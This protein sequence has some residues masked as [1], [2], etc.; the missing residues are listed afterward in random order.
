MIMRSLPVDENLLH[1]VCLYVC[2]SIGHSALSGCREAAAV[3]RDLRRNDVI[4]MKAGARCLRS[5]AIKLMTDDVKQPA[6]FR[7]H[8]LF[9]GI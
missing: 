4:R 6:T 7:R 3:S 9:A 2:L 1:S 8:V 5:R